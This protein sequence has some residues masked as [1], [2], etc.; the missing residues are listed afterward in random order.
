MANTSRNK[1]EFRFLFFDLI[2]IKAHETK[3]MVE[4]ISDIPPKLNRKF[5]LTRSI[6]NE[7]KIVVAV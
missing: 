1:K 2:W 5:E 6:S 3:K 7:I 4:T